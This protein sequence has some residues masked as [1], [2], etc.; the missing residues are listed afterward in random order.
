[1]SGVCS[2]KPTPRKPR[3]SFWRPM[4]GCGPILCRPLLW[5]V[6]PYTDQTCVSFSIRPPL[7]AL[8]GG[9]TCPASSIV[10]IILQSRF[11]R[12]R[13]RQQLRLLLCF[14]MPMLPACSFPYAGAP[15]SNLATFFCRSAAAAI[16]SMS[17]WIKI[18]RHARERI[19]GSVADIAKELHR[20]HFVCYC[21]KP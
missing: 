4:F 11:Q 1:M 18:K 12:Q 6:T 15:N 17:A 16:T 10:S 13:Y 3:K 2:A 21:P 8:P 7:S 9:Y 5:P 20:Q 19:S 14:S